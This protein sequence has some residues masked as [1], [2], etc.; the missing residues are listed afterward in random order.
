MT[1]DISRPVEDEGESMVC[2]GQVRKMDFMGYRILEILLDFWSCVAS[3]VY[4]G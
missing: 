2:D 1:D 4:T 3:E